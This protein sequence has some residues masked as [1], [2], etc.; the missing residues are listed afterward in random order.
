MEYLDAIGLKH[1]L[2]FREKERQKF[3]KENLGITWNSSHQW[4]Y[5]KEY[6]KIQDNKKVISAIKRYVGEEKEDFKDLIIKAFINICEISAEEC[7]E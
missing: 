3:M 5:Q 4:E 7:T 1:G 6:K 2:V